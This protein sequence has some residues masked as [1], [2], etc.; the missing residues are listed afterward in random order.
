MAGQLE[1]WKTLASFGVNSARRPAFQLRVQ[2]RISRFEAWS[3]LKLPTLADGLQNLVQEESQQY[4]TADDQIYTNIEI[5]K[6]TSP[7]WRTSNNTPR[8]ALESYLY[9]CT[10]AA[11]QP[12]QQRCRPRSE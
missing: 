5:L 1:S 10:C 4:L 7:T 11:R 12:L 6:D 3:A 2:A 9:V 8:Y